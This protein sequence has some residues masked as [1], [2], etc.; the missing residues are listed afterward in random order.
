[1]TTLFS[2]IAVWGLDLVARESSILKSTI[3]YTNKGFFRK[4][5]VGASIG[6]TLNAGTSCG[7]CIPELNA[8]ISSNQRGQSEA[9]PS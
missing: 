2:V 1:V 6:K 5:V 3:T 9:L 7:S 4:E 8:L